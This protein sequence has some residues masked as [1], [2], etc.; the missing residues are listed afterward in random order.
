MTP[1][2]LRD[3]VGGG[4]VERGGKKGREGGDWGE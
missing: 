3:A 2:L 1:S 4:G